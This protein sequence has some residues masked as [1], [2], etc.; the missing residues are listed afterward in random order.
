MMSVGQIAGTWIRVGS[1]DFIDE[2]EPRDPAVA[3]HYMDAFRS[4]CERGFVLHEG[5]KLFVLT[6]IGFDRARSI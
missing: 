1:K 4:L 6:G 3:A 5:D 2:I